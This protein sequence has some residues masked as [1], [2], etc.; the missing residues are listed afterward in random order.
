MII[1]LHMNLF[2]IFNI[3]TLLGSVGWNV[4]FIPNYRELKITK[5]L[6]MKNAHV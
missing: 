1:G 4:Q 2:A 3:E 6:L 5:S